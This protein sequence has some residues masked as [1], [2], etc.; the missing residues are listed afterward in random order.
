V[1]GTY[2]PKLSI[3]HGVHDWGLRIIRAAP[4]SGSIIRVMWG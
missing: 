4:S 2:T 1:K 3:M